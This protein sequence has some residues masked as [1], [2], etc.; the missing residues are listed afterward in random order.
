MKIIVGI[1]PGVETGVAV[2]ELGQKEYA[3]IATMPIHT[4]IFYVLGLI[5]DKNNDVYVIFEDARKR[6]WF[7]D[8]GMTVKGSRGLAMGAASVKRDCTIWEDFLESQPVRW[9]AVAPR[10]GT[11]KIDAAVFARLTG[12]TGRT[13]N[14]ARDAAMLIQGITPQSLK[15]HFK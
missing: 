1:D 2:R 12:Y 4:A 7:N 8:S 13:S 15:L 10:K 5:N 14:H 3:K 6:K 11:T 9:A